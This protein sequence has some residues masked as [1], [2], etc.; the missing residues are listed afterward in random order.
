MR[1]G[2]GRLR[3]QGPAPWHWAVMV[4]ILDVTQTSEDGVGPRE[5]GS[6]D[7]RGCDSRLSAE[8]HLRL[9]KSLTCVSD[10]P[11]TF[12]KNHAQIQLSQR[13][14]GNGVCSTRRFS[15]KPELLLP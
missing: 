8:G 10:S 4:S 15:Q 6:K 11:V 12:P 2:P 9:G 1:P 13:R 14:Q 5:K 7:R 3:P